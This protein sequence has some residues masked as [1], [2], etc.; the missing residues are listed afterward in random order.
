MKREGCAHWR[1]MEWIGFY[2]EWKIGSL[3]MELIGGGVGPAYGRT[4]FDYRR[5][6]VWDFKAHPLWDS[7][8]KPNEPMILNDQSAIL[9]CA[10]EHGGIGFVV[11]NGRAG[12]NGSAD[13]KAWHDEL[14]GGR[15]EYERQRVE[16]G[17]GS[18]TRKT[19]FEALRL[20]LYWFG[21]EAR[22]RQGVSEG[23]IGS[24]QEGMRN[25]DGSPRSAKFSIRTD[26]VPSWAVPVPSEEL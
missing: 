10:R 9:S 23:W 4:K 7:H 17:A 25:S 3:L 11:V 1:Q 2:Y 5:N 19:S 13:F 20:D 24:F 6:H 18:R 14:K 15:S 26:R 8:G 12:F 16:R 21:S 22:I